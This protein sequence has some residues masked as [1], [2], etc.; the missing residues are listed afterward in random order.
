M[1][2]VHSV[3]WCFKQLGEMSKNGE[4]LPIGRMKNWQSPWWAKKSPD[5]EKF[6]TMGEFSK[7]DENCP[8]KN[9]FII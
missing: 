1:Q 7:L 9:D 3:Q 5:W 4:I 6:S 8:N 2:A